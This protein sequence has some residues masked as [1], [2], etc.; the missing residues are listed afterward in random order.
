SKWS[1]SYSLIKTTTIVTPEARSVGDA[2]RKLDAK[3][4]INSDFISHIRSLGESPIFVLDGKTNECV[5]CE[6]VEFYPRK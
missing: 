4:L 5:H 1:R 2:L 6:T 3:Q